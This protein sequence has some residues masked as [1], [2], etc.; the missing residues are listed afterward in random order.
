[1]ITPLRPQRIQIYLVG[2][3]QN[4]NFQVAEPA[5]TPPK[6][7]LPQNVLVIVS[8]RL[9]TERCSVT[10]NPFIAAAPAKSL[11]IRAEFVTGYRRENSGYNH[12]GIND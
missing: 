7:N 12:Y 5:G 6:F 10:A 9:L 2:M 11:T 3:K 1:M 8:Q 4:K